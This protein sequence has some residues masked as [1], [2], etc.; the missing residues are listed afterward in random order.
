M[1]TFMFYEFHL[2]KKRENIFIDVNI[3]CRNIKTN[4]MTS[5]KLRRVF[6]SGEE[7]NGIK[8]EF[9]GN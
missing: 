4:R 2:N 1:V 8:A 7:G 9:A 3:C 5:T 6:L